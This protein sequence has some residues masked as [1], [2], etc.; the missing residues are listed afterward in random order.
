LD[1]PNVSK[2]FMLEHALIA[3]NWPIIE[4]VMQYLQFK[5]NNDNVADVADDADDTDDDVY[6]SECSF[7]FAHFPQHNCPKCHGLSIRNPVYQHND[8]KTHSINYMPWVWFRKHNPYNGGSAHPE[9]IHTD[10]MS[11]ERMTRR[12]LNI[13]LRRSTIHTRMGNLN[14]GSFFEACIMANKPDWFMD[15][16]YSAKTGG[17]NSI[18]LFYV[19][20]VLSD[21]ENNYNWFKSTIKNLLETA[22]DGDLINS[23][24]FLMKLSNIAK[25][26]A[27][28]IERLMD[29]MNIKYDTDADAED[30]EFEPMPV[31]PNEW[32]TAGGITL[33]LLVFK[34]FST[35]KEE[36]L[37]RY[38]IEKWFTEKSLAKF[39]VADGNSSNIGTM[40][41][42]LTDRSKSKR[43]TLFLFRLKEDVMLNLKHPYETLNNEQKL[44]RLKFIDT[45]MK[46]I[47]D[48][49]EGYEE[50]W[51]TKSSDYN[52]IPHLDSVRTLFDFFLSFEVFSLSDWDIATK[53]TRFRHFRFT[54]LC[55]HWP[56]V[57]WDKYIIL[58]DQPSYYLINPH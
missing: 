36:A 39:L 13:L 40:L 27:I 48:D 16:I 57:N 46:S 51:Y 54:A 32:A 8:E 31:S 10:L 15:V 28:N 34:Y 3:G 9:L 44:N 25:Y 45:V 18:V 42:K 21:G 23:V 24:F 47:N 30:L 50:G 17:A 29:R 11:A 19:M 38:I 55:K 7:I 1:R 33:R 26:F 4:Y 58:F 37:A 6:I 12:N 35:C 49:E 5:S 43:L 20:E 56:M 2:S 14:P 53:I 22:L 41:Y 52:Y